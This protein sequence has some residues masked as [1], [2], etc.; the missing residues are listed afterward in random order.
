MYILLNKLFFFSILFFQKM[1]HKKEIDE[2]DFFIYV[3]RVL[4]RGVERPANIMKLSHNDFTQK[5]V[6]RLC[7]DCKP[8]HFNH[9]YGFSVGGV[10]YTFVIDDEKYITGFGLLSFETLS[11][12]NQSIV[13]LICAHSLG[14][15]S[16]ISHR[17]NLSP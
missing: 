1:S 11:L 2:S 14:M 4:P 13:T 9:Y 15:Q 8:H 12:T 16:S 17:L 3:G 5:D 7:F 6:D 10:R